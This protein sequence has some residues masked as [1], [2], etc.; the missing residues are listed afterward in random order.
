MECKKNKLIKIKQS[1]KKQQPN[2]KI[3][4]DNLKIKNDKSA[5]L[6]KKQ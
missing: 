1:K 5:L 4:Y 3:I 6:Y 2:N